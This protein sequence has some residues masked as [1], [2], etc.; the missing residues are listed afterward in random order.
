MTTG[1]GYTTKVT[2][3]YVAGNLTATGPMNWQPNTTIQWPDSGNTIALKPDTIAAWY[4]GE[5]DQKESGL[6]GDAFIDI[7]KQMAELMAKDIDRVI[8][9]TKKEKKMPENDE[10]TVYNVFVVDPEDDGKVIAKLENVIAKSA[11]TAK[12]KAVLQLAA[13]EDKLEK[14]LED[15]DL[16]VEDVADFGSIRPK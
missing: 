16:L 10:R 15:Y 11:E 12:L 5:P 7:R 9:G 14:D 1:I 3:G 13:N 4:R 2:L 8:M 6:S